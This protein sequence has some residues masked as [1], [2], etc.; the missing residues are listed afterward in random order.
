L[1]GQLT[2]NK[3]TNNWSLLVVKWLIGK[4]LLV[5]I[6]LYNIRFYLFT[7]DNTTALVNM[8]NEKRFKSFY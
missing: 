5:T 4:R 1:S 7:L 6:Y 8:N 2:T 3:T